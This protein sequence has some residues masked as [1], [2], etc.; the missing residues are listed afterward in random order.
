M[1]KYRPNDMNASI[2]RP[3]NMNGHTTNKV[4]SLTCSSS[5]RRSR[6]DRRGL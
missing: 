6:L 2:A 3:Q 1:M 5:D 4:S